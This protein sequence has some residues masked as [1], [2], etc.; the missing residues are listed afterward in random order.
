VE[1]AVAVV[2]TDVVPRVRLR[3]EVRVAVAVAVEEAVG[4]VRGKTEVLILEEELA[5]F[6][7]V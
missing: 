2:G 6:M 5:D 7:R 1:E 3:M 4:N